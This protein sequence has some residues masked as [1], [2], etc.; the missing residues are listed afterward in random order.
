MKWAKQ[1]NVI[2]GLWA[3][4]T[5]ATV[6]QD[7]GFTPL[8][9]KGIKEVGMAGVVVKAED[10]C[11]KGP[12][13]ISLARQSPKTEGQKLLRTSQEWEGRWLSSCDM[14]MIKGKCGPKFFKG[15]KTVILHGHIIF[16]FA[17]CPP[18]DLL[19]S[20]LWI[21]FAVPAWKMS[22][23]SR[24]RFHMTERYISYASLSTIS[25]HTKCTSRLESKDMFKSSSDLYAMEIQ[26]KFSGSK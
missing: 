20:C 4:T 23:K 5:F 7:L 11:A 24:F 17:I 10:A 2:S 13:L 3:R 25:D 21:F 15:M 6:W 19:Y 8:G 12:R 9:K 14:W 1:R 22:F 18:W 26:G 16:S